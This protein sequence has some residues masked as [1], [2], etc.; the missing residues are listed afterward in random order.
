MSAPTLSQHGG[1]EVLV[2]V[3]ASDYPKLVKHLRTQQP[4]SLKVIGHLTSNVK[5]PDWKT[6]VYVDSWSHLS[7]VI[8]L[9]RKHIGP[10]ITLSDTDI[11]LH[12]TCSEKLK[13][14]LL[15]ST[16]IDWGNTV[17]FDGIDDALLPDLQEIAPQSGKLKLEFCANIHLHTNTDR[18]N[19]ATPNGTLLSPLTVAEARIVLKNWKFGRDWM[20]SEIEHII[21]T[22]LTSG[23][24]TNEGEL[25]AWALEGF[26]GGIGFVHTLENHRRKGYAKIV[27][28][29]LTK[30]MLTAG[31]TPWAH[32]E[33]HSEKGVSE[34]LLE[35][36][37]FL[38][39]DVR[40]A[41]IGFA[42]HGK[43]IIW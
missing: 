33:D 20:L 28:A 36:V 40:Q 14:I 27:V 35:S 38:K 23:L 11:Y 24:F 29:D 41:F 32:V 34:R 12:S 25:V 18:L 8:C 42:P 37:G 1:L 2:P 43:E 4:H 26:Y 5:S 13:E 22:N 31:Q 3:S 30:K 9:N 6:E 15:N 17:F 21:Q 16:V 10:Y 7:V 19:W 39:S